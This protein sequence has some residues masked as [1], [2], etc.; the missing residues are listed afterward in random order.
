MKKIV[1]VLT[2]TFLSIT[3]ISCQAF[4]KDT[5]LPEFENMYFKYAVETKDDG[6]QIG[7]LTGFT[8]LGLT[9]EALVLPIEID[10]IKIIGIGYRRKLAFFGNEIIS[11]FQSDALEKMFIPFEITSSNEWRWDYDF[12]SLPNCLI[13]NWTENE[14]VRL[15]LIKGYIHTFHSYQNNPSFPINDQL[16][17][18]KIANVSYMY[19]YEGAPHHGYYWID[20]YNHSKISYI[21]E[22]PIREG[23]QFDGWFKDTDFIH[24]WDFDVD[25]TGDEIIISS[26]LTA[27]TRV[28]LY[29]KWIN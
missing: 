29:A 9:Q 15:G 26:T 16:N 28:M 27:Y 19:N 17:V 25:Q 3:L 14:M 23:Y 1:L 18:R 6:T 11:Q 20:S 7:Y 5:F 22:N 10:G 24:P 8:E 12:G 4:Q 13:V 2:I 21:P